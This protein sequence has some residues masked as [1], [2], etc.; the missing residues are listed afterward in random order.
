MPDYSN[1]KIYK[2]TSEKGSYV[3]STTTTLS[4]RLSEHLSKM[5]RALKG[6]CHY[7]SSF[8]VIHDA[9]EKIEIVL[10]EAFPCG[11]KMELEAREAEV[12]KSIDCV[13]QICSG[14][15]FKEKTPLQQMI[16]DLTTEYRAKCREYNAK[17]LTD[18][19]YRA[20]LN[21]KIRDAKRRQRADP[22][23]RAERNRREREARKAV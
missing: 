15:Y 16:H 21:K 11:S 9:K 4:K 12:I 18:P 8:E 17:R 7:F 2:I 23:Y 10:I 14:K 5:K 20:E 1:G 19:V 22:E 13:N 6:K 3:G